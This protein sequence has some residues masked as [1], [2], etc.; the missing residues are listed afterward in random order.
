MNKLFLILITAFLLNVTPAQEGFPI[1]VVDATGRELTFDT[2][3]KRIV[4]L[5]TACVHD[6]SILG[7]MPIAAGP[8]GNV[9]A[10]RDAAVFGTAAEA[11]VTLPWVDGYDFEALAAL[12]PD[13]IVGWVGIDEFLPLEAMAGIAP[14]YMAGD[15]MR[16]QDMEQLS[17]DLMN[18]AKLLGRE[19]TAE[20]FITRL[21]Q[22]LAAYASLTETQQAVYAVVRLSDP[23]TGLIAVP[24]DCGAFMAQ[25]ATCA[26]IS[27]DWQEISTEGLLSFDPPVIISE[28]WGS[29]SG[30]TASPAEWGGVTLWSELS[31]VQSKQVY[32]LPPNRT[33]AYSTLSVSLSIDTLMPL[34]YPQVF[35][36]PL[37][38][39]QV[40]DIL[41]DSN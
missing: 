25:L 4:C 37:T 1:T 30:G 11:I 2:S 19:A 13:L 28:D 12:K 7:V 15:P 29:G 33:L 20:A 5:L 23:N 3:P 32:H 17:R 39:K 24:P 21:E 9:A 35:P 6:L 14:L 27:E 10:A 26:I 38:D 31:A 8:E 40:E 41:A 16:A 36:E 22:R 34:L 18:Y